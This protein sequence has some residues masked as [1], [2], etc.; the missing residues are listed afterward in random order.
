MPST[1]LCVWET[2]VS[3]VQ[4]TVWRGREAR[5]DNHMM[6][7]SITDGGTG[8]ALWKHHT[9]SQPWLEGVGIFPLTWYWRD[10][11]KK[12]REQHMQR[13][14]GSRH[15]MEVFTVRGD[16]VWDEATETDKRQVSLRLA[17]QV[18]NLYLHP[19]YKQ[20]STKCCQEGEVDKIIKDYLCYS[21]EKRI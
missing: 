11:S 18:K 15:T 12:E 20:K 3:H 14:R 17:G 9:K 16:L 4:L 2:M 1:V 7:C 10:E 5:S 8:Q 21:V 19:K 6:K 13:P